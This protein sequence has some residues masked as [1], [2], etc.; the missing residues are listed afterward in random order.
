MY[1]ICYIGSSYFLFFILLLFIKRSCVFKITLAIY[2][3]NPP[4]VHNTYFLL[5]CLLGSFSIIL[6]GVA[7]GMH[8]LLVCIL[9]MYEFTSID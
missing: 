9:C 1:D 5:M 3:L 8:L 4:L 2:L 7:P 6:E